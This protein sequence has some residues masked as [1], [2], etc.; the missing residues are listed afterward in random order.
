MITQAQTPAYKMELA[1][2]QSY[3]KNALPYMENVRTLAPTQAKLWA[4][5]LQMIYE[6]LQMKDKK[7]E[8]DEII[9]GL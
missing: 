5:T 8:I 7:K 3:Y 1:L 6:N 9:K 4:Y 2:V